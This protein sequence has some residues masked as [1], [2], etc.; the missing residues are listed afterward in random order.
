MVGGELAAGCAAL[1]HR[2]TA[3]LR[4]GRAQR[5]DALRAAALVETRGR[6]APAFAGIAGAG[7]AVAGGA[8]G[9]GA[10]ALG[11]HRLEAGPVARAQDARHALLQRL[12][13]TWLDQ[14]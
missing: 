7:A 13:L 14:G 1:P 10:A 8:G 3:A 4:G 11:R 5:T 9:A 12:L 6:A 2:R